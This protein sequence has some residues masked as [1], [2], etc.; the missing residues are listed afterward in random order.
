MHK[1]IFIANNRQMTH[2]QTGTEALMCVGQAQRRKY[3]QVCSSKEERGEREGVA[4]K[5]ASLLTTLLIVQ[6][7]P[8]SLR[9]VYV[10]GWRHPIPNC[11]AVKEHQAELLEQGY[12]ITHQFVPRSV[13]Q[14]A[15]VP[16]EM[17]YTVPKQ[18]THNR[19]QTHSGYQGQSVIKNLNTTRGTFKCS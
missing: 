5:H 2:A 10:L 3:D 13:F 9:D 16:S 7:P 1:A 17:A 15:Y 19:N 6:K 11:R 8:S 18:Q 12:T 4:P 14:L